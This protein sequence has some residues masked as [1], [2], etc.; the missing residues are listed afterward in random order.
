[1][2]SIRQHRMKYVHKLQGECSIFYANLLELSA[3]QMKADLCMYR[4]SDSHKNPDS[5]PQ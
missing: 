3:K 2:L 4:V 1:M 5:V